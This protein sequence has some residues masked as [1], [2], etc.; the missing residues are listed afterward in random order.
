MPAREACATERRRFVPF[1]ADLVERYEREG[2]WTDVTL[3]GALQASA[4]RAPEAPALVCGERRLTYRQ[5]CDSAEQL[6]W[7][8]RE[9]GLCAGERVLLQL[10]NVAEFVEVCFALF[11]LGVLPILAHPAHREHELASLQEQTQAAAWC[12]AARHAGQDYRELVRSLRTR[13]GAGALRHV[14]VVGEPQEFTG[15]EAVRELGRS[16]LERADRAA[17]LSPNA[18]EPALLQLSGGSTATPKLIP[19]THADYG[20]SI[21]AAIECCGFDA[22]TRYLVALPAAHNFPL[23]SPGSLGA[24]F[25]GGSVVM[26]PKPDPHTAFQVIARERVTHTAL[27]PPLLRLWSDARRFRKEDLSSLQVLQVGGAKLDPAAARA[28]PTVFG[29]ALQQVFGMAEGL[30]CFT[31]ATDTAELVSTTQGLPSSSADELR[32]VDEQDQDVP[33]GQVGHLLTRGPYTIRG[34]YA[35][36]EH[37][38]QAFTSDGYYRT[39]DLVR[40]L[41]TGHLIVEG[42][43]KDQINRGGEKIAAPEVEA[44]LR[45][46][47]AVADVALVGMPDTLLGERSHAFVVCRSDAPSAEAL[48]AFL[49]ASGLAAFK[50]PDRFEFVADLPQTSVGKIDKRALRAAAAADSP[51]RSPSAAAERAAGAP[52]HSPRG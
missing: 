7:G 2:L 8:F 3:F 36:P 20:Y 16:A 47:P 6:A 32:I 14:V 12:I 39:G 25:A 22:S 42:R 52:A 15:L 10:P 21:R 33:A 11:R 46:H 4:A 23:S 31:R 29:C 13:R 38:A 1:P 48:H 41:P 5:L 26:L 27:V 49:R 40:R 18:R 9:L 24:L 51:R 19:R 17:P 44:A 35:A 30:V 50:L 28:V 45:A 37:D 34:Y 43:A